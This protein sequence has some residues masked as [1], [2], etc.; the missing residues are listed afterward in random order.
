LHP[1]I[2]RPGRCLAHIHVGR[3]SQLEAT[4]WLDNGKRVGVDGAT[5][6]ELLALRGDF[7]QVHRPEEARPI[8][9]YL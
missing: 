9:Q 1:A 5:L 7:D 6:A 3:L 8:G 4:R 2:V